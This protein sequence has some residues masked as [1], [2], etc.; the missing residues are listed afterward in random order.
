MSLDV[1]NTGAAS[2]LILDKLRGGEADAGIISLV[3]SSSRMEKNRFLW[4]LYYSRFVQA[5]LVPWMM[6]GLS[7]RCFNSRV[8]LMSSVSYAEV[9]FSSFF[10]PFA[11]S[12]WLVLFAWL[13]VTGSTLVVLKYAMN[14][15]VV[16]ENENSLNWYF[17][18]FL[19]PFQAMLYQGKKSKLFFFFSSNYAKR[20][21]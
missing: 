8:Y 19:I 18:T 4:P 7:H 2:P 1:V 5:I 10:K 6:S 20:D 12:F 9:N 11:R 13:T 14:R 3:L 15:L 21:S 16:D 17:T